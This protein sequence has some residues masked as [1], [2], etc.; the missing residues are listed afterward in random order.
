MSDETTLLP[1]PFCG[2]DAKLEYDWSR[3][4]FSCMVYCE[5]DPSIHRMSVV[6]PLLKAGDEQ[7]AIDVITASWNRRAALGSGKLT[8]EQVREAAYTHMREY[9]SPTDPYV[10][11]TEYNW[12][13]IA[14][15]LN[16]AIGGGR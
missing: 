7:T 16:A 8:T 9:A 4:G 14:D 15:E 5:D 12:Q 3:D 13:A 6:F 1:C 2:G 11:L 10:Y